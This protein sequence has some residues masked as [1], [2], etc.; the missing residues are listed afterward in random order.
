MNTTLLLLWAG[1]LF[2][3]FSVTLYFLQK[4]RSGSCGCA[5]TGTASGT[6]EGFADAAPAPAPAPAAKQADLETLMRL[7]RK[8]GGTL[9]N[10]SL[11]LERYEMI[12]K[13]PVELARMY[14]NSKGKAE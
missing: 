2:F 4:V 10:P 13:D 1:L 5:A 7:A 6:A 11:W 3:S 14:M 9:L 12:G 8:L